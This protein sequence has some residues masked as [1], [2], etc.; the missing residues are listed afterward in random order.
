MGEG[1]TEAKVEVSAIAGEEAKDLRDNVVEC[2]VQ[3]NVN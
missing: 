1:R 2:N 3:M